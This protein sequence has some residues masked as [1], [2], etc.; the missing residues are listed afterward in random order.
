MQSNS[1][2]GPRG[3][4]RQYWASPQFSAAR[5]IRPRALLHVKRGSMRSCG[6]TNAQR[7]TALR[8]MRMR[9]RVRRR[10]YGAARSRIEWRRG[11]HPGCGKDER[12]AGALLLIAQTAVP[13]GR[14]REPAPRRRHPLQIAAPAAPPPLL[15]LLL[16]RVLMLRATGRRKG[17]LGASPDG[18]EGMRR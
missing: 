5:A 8:S 16:R 11:G 3:P 17:S 9:R 1:T 2:H 6:C 18:P 13:G 15:L 12:A 7:H 4:P 14:V 10:R